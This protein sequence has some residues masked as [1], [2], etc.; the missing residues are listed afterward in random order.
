MRRCAT[1]FTSGVS[2]RPTAISFSTCVAMGRLRLGDDHLRELPAHEH[3]ARVVLGNVL[4]HHVGLAPALV[5]VDH[6][7]SGAHAHPELDRLYEAELHSSVEAGVHDVLA[8][9]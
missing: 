4:G 1:S 8:V 3:P 5:L 9:P 2:A 6:L 7:A